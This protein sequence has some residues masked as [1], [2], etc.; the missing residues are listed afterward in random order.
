ME[1]ARK[2]GICLQIIDKIY[3]IGKEIHHEDSDWLTQ[4]A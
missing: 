3:L 1:M 2:N 4:K